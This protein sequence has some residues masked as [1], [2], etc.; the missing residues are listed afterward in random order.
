MFYSITSS[1]FARS[2]AGTV[3]ET[4]FAAFKLRLIFPAIEATEP[5][6]RRR[7]SMGEKLSCNILGEAICPYGAA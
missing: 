7:P 4:A 2:V 5:I 3:N 6:R 1:A